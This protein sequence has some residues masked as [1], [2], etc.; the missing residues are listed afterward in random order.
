MFAQDEAVYNFYVLA[1]TV[2][3]KYTYKQFTL[4]N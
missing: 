4:T 1:Q 2:T 3:N